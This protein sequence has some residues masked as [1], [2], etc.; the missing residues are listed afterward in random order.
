MRAR[1]FS[2]LLFLGSCFNAGASHIVG[3]EITY[4]HLGSFSYEIKL[5][6]FVDCQNG[7]PQ[8]IADDL[9]ARIGVFDGSSGQL[10]TTLSRE[11][12]R[13]GP[14]RVQKLNYNCVRN[15]P[16]QCV[17]KY[18]YTFTQTLAQRTG[19]YFLSFQRCCRNQIISNIYD[20]GFTGAN[21]WTYI[22]QVNGS[23]GRGFNS[24]PV[25][26]ELPPNFLCTNAWLNFDHSA[27]DPDND[28]LVYEFFT[29]YIAG[30][31]ND[32][33]PTFN[34]YD[35]PPF[36]TLQ[37]IGSYNYANPMDGNPKFKID[38]ETGR[39]TGI[40]TRE[41]Q[42]V[43]GIKVK[44]YRNGVLIGETK[45]DYQFYVY[46]CIVD[47]VSAFYAPN[48]QC[49]YRVTFNNQSQGAQRYRWDFGV[50]GRSDDTSNLTNPVFDY[51]GPGLYRI[52]L[53]AFRSNCVDS[54][55]MTVQVYPPRYPNLGP[56]TLICGAF[57]FTLRVKESGFQYNWNT[58]QTG[59]SI[60]IN[61]GGLYWVE[62]V[63]G[64]CRWRD[65]I[66][67][68]NDLSRVRV[69]GDT[70][71]CNERP[72]TATL[73]A[74]AGY[75][76]YTWNNGSPN[77]S[78]QATQVGNYWVETENSNGCI[79]RDTARIDQYPELILSLRDTTICPGTSTFRD[80]G[81]P[82]A[83]YAWSD[84][85]STR[86]AEFKN[87]GTYS[88]IVRR[89]KCSENGSFVLN[90]Y[91]PELE[92]GPDTAFCGNVNRRLAPLFGRNFQTYRWN[93]DVSD[94]V[95]TVSLPGKY[96][97]RV[98]TFNGCTEN[99]SVNIVLNPLPQFRL[100]PDTN[101]C[102]SAVLELDPGPYSSYRWQDGDDK[103]TKKTFD[104][105]LYAVEVTDEN[106]CKNS[107][108]MQVEKDPSKLPS[109]MY[110]PSAFTPNGDGWND[111]FPG[112]GFRS[113]DGF[114]EMKVFNRW[115]EKLWEANKPA[116][117]W[118]GRINN[119]IVPEGVYIYMVNWIG[120]DNRRRSLSGNVSVLK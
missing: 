81:N 27:T 37:W 62:K 107:D 82:G 110:V 99:D 63:D 14:T 96:Y 2:I 86:V 24:S 43:V 64:R 26:K 53:I 3:G 23:G 29:P 6:L 95:L 15:L 65:T 59:M 25:F 108:T 113:D 75:R 116:L 58:T 98:T 19:G 102:L 105:G 109:D 16:N 71:I 32:P 90:Q 61:R 68:T 38:P 18:E 47:V 12:R 44:E 17:D 119:Q 51:P 77:R 4:R 30:D 40:P 54:S 79:T 70:V 97:L 49:G 55:E 48:Y 101:I 50:A 114:Y 74:G 33:R 39:L 87:P 36:D 84:G 60:N 93:G 34:N 45:R 1:L 10:L 78:I 67:I 85:Q 35:R 111:V 46:R 66:V 117:N 28:S 83:T 80:A 112:H 76:R 31:R 8:A 88:V 56:D 9:N 72:F 118:D 91:A 103:R 57:T 94:P 115:G 100:P 21:Y 7:S 20:P 104:A 106:G 22:P 13:T 42:Y 5:T 52:K 11:V 41:G 73:D 89:D 69:T 120:C 92:L